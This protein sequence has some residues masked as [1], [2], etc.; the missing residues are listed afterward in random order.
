MDWMGA[1]SD[2]PMVESSS[3]RPLWLKERERDDRPRC[4][5]VSGDGEEEEE[6]AAAAVGVDWSVKGRERVQ[7]TQ[8]LL[9]VMQKRS[10]IA[11]KVFLVQS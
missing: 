4:A 9:Q 6:A 2:R 10:Q 1:L 7:F 5:Q 11:T 8:C 3:V